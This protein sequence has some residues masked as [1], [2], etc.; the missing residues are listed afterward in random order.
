[1]GSHFPDSMSIFRQIAPGPWRIA[2]LALLFIVCAGVV[3]LSVSVEQATLVADEPFSPPGTALQIPAA[4]IHWIIPALVVLSFQAAARAWASTPRVR[5]LLT[6]AA[7]IALGAVWLADLV[8]HDRWLSLFHCVLILTVLSSGF[9]IWRY[10]RIRPVGLVGT[11]IVACLLGLVSYGAVWGETR[12]DEP[13]YVRCLEHSGP[14]VW[15]PQ[16]LG[17]IGVAVFADLRHANLEGIR[18]AGRDLRYA[19]MRGA[20]LQ[21]AN[22]AGTNL[23]RARLE[24]IRARESRWHSAYL[25]GA[26]MAGADLRAADL[27]KVHAYRLDLRNADLSGADLRRASLSHAYLEGTGFDGARMQR[28][29]LRYSQGLFPGQLRYACGDRDTRLPS[30]ESLAVCTNP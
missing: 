12:C 1:M 4:V 8:R 27:R 6:I 29:Y 15:V 19:D 9:S 16:I 18:L 2:T 24:D 7:L 22:L 5:A 11:A 13:T 3:F 10:G 23:R 26:S 14:R 25:D 20:V 30:G 21:G 28:A 17:H